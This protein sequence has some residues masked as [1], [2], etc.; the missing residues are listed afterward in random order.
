[1]K[2]TAPFVARCAP[3][4]V[5]MCNEVHV[6]TSVNN[7]APAP[8]IYRAQRW[9]K[10]KV[11]LVRLGFGCVPTAASVAPCGLRSGA[12]WDESL[13]WTAAAPSI[14]PLHLSRRHLP[15]PVFG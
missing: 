9:D 4:S 11:R 1:M 10:T 15:L 5:C 6:V 13:R 14:R 12:H 8:M 2:R 7:A 3:S